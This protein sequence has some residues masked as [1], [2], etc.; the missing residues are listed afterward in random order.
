[1]IVSPSNAHP[2][3]LATAPNVN[4][5]YDVLSFPMLRYRLVLADWMDP[6]MLKYSELDSGP[7]TA[8]VSEFHFRTVVLELTARKVTGKRSWLS[9]TIARVGLQ[10][11]VENRVLDASNLLRL[12]KHR[13]E[14]GEGH[15]QCREEDGQHRRFSVVG[16]V[17][18]GK[19]GIRAGSLITQ[20]YLCT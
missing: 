20:A 18:T 13:Q 1:M 19:A 15:H 11:L 17:E 9:H 3:M 7:I 8:T 12:C 5:L 6:E 16:G 10:I 14:A 2:L 4:V